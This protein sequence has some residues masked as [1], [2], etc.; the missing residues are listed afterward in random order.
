MRCLATTARICKELGVEQVTVDY[1]FCD[2]MSEYLYSKNPVPNI[3]LRKKSAADLNKEYELQDVA[4]TDND[5][6][7]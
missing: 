2:L 7:F 4:F 1:N 3:E 6:G 5:D